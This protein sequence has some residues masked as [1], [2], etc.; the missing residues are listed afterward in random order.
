MAATRI[1]SI[2]LP[3]PLSVSEATRL[4]TQLMPHLVTHSSKLRGDRIKEEPSL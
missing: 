1:S 2:H 4:D 3:M